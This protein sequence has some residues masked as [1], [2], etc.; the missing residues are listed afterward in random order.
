MPRFVLLYEDA[1]R[2][3]L[4]AWAACQAASGALRAG[5]LTAEGALRV[6][7]GG[8]V[9]TV[10]PARAEPGVFVVEAE[11]ERAALA[12]AASGPGPVRIL[13]IAPD[14]EVGG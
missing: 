7:R 2:E 8:G 9:V 6:S 3:P 12:L 13:A 14:G 11:D 10:A 4:V 5:G 1:A